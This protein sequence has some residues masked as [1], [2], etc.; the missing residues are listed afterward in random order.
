ME[1]RGVKIHG[2]DRVAFTVVD[3]LVSVWLD[4]AQADVGANISGDLEGRP[5]YLKSVVVYGTELDEGSEI[6]AG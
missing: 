2:A 6:A 4:P 1:L 3:G 5:W